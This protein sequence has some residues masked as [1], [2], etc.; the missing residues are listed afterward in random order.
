MA[1]GERRDAHAG[2]GEGWAASASAGVTSIPRQRIDEVTICAR[3]GD[4]PSHYAKVLPVAQ[5]DV[6]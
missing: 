2:Q 4:A 1:R 3:P 6:R 5:Y